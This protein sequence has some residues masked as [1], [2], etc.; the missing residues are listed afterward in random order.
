MF[1]KHQGEHLEFERIP[2]GERA[3]RRPDLCGMLY[4]DA[5]FGG[6]GDAVTHAEH[7]QIWFAFPTDELTEAD[8]IYLLRCGI[9][10]DSENDSLYSFV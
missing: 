10:F 9:L 6:A 8:V 5:R 2:L 1:E 3:H 7:D 4:L